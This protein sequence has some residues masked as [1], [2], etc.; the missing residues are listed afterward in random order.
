[1][2]CKFLTKPKMRFLELP[3]KYGICHMKYKLFVVL[4]ILLSIDL[5]SCKT[6]SRVVEETE[7]KPDLKRDDGKYSTE[8][9]AYS[10][11]GIGFSMKFGSDWDFHSPSSISDGP[12]KK[13]LSPSNP[14]DKSLFYL[15]SKDMSSTVSVAF[16]DTGIPLEKYFNVMINSSDIYI[17]IY[18]DD[19]KINNIGMKTAVFKV[20][21]GKNGYICVN[22]VFMKNGNIVHISFRT[23]DSLFEKKRMLFDKIIYLLELN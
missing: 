1:M 12:V 13:F 21:E 10:N 6:G 3:L 18:K 19:L 8:H 16:N 23:A 22:Y 7:K 4:V 20:N 15:T 14:D 9:G 5:A 2:G 11:T 17:L